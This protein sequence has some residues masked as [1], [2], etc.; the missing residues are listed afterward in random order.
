M[1]IILEEDKLVHHILLLLI[2]GSMVVLMRCAKKFNHIIFHKNKKKIGSILWTH[3]NW[4]LKPGYKYWISPG[5]CYRSYRKEQLQNKQARWLQR[6]AFHIW[7]IARF[8]CK[9]ILRSHGLIREIW[10]KREERMQLCGSGLKHELNKLSSADTQH[11]LLWTTMNSDTIIAACQQQLAVIACYHHW[12]W[13]N[14]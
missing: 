5:S 3:W 4:A 2:G 8:G 1:G 11:C 10:E 9:S 6:I 14:R 13:R 7:N 12:F